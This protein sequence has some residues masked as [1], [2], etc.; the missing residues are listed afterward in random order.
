VGEI[1]RLLADLKLANNTIVVFSSDNGFFLGEHGL[2]HKWLM[3][4]ESIRI[5]LIISDPRRSSSSAGRRLDQLVLNIDLAPTLLDLAGAEIPPG[6]DGQSL[7]P[8]LAGESPAWRT[9]FFYEHHFH[10]AG[11]IPRTEGVR[12]ANWK[13]ITYS[14]V[15]PVF[16]ELYDLAADPHEE[17]NLAGDPAYRE[18]LESLRKRYGD[19]VARL[20]P[21]VLPVN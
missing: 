19:Y 13:Y 15:E 17:H 2:S 7:R 20:G 1:R 9:D 12:T 5:P 16:E 6:T 8:L 3:H 10:Y 4:E 21:P 14:G 18:R 11:K